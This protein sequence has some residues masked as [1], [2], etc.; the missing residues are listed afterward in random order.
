MAEG[1]SGVGEAGEGAPAAHGDRG[2]GKAS[3]ER[4]SGGANMLMMV[5]LFT[6]MVVV[7]IAMLV[8]RLLDSALPRTCGA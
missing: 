7:T 2:K 4:K 1:S 8:S 3:K 6:V 5:L